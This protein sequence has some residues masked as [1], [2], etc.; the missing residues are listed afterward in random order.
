MMDARYADMRDDDQ[1]ELGSLNTEEHPA[2]RNHD[3]PWKSQFM[4]QKSRGGSGSASK[5]QLSP[6]QQRF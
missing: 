4:Q 6:P 1:V 5:K 2:K 3:S